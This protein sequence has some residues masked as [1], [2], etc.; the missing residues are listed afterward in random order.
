M[1]I[2]I[3][4]LLGLLKSGLTVQAQ[5][6]VESL[7]HELALRDVLNF[8]LTKFLYSYIIINLLLMPMSIN[9]QNIS[10]IDSLKRELANLDSQKQ[11][12]ANDT[13][14]IQLLYS[15]TKAYYGLSDSSNFYQKRLTTIS[16]GINWPVGKFYSALTAGLNLSGRGKYYEAIEKYY[17][18]LKIAEEINRKNL[19]GLALR[20]LADCFYSLKQYKKSIYYLKKASLLVNSKR[21]YIQYLMCLNNI[22]MSYIELNKLDV[23]EKIL[24]ECLIKNKKSNTNNE[25]IESYCHEQLANLYQK[26][27]LFSKA[28]RNMI[29]SIDIRKKLKTDELYELYPKLAEIYFSKNDLVKAKKFADSSVKYS[30]KIHT[31]YRAQAFEIN[32]KIYKQLGESRKSLYYY[33]RYITLRDSNESN[34]VKKIIDGMYFEFENNKYQINVKNLNAV[35]KNENNIKLLLF[36][37]LCLFFLMTSILYYLYR[38]TKSQKTKIELISE[39]YKMLNE[40]LEERIQVRTTE[41]TIKNEELLRKNQEIQEAYFTGKI[42]ERKR[43]ASELHDNLGS[44]ITGLLWQIDAINTDNFSTRERKIYTSLVMK[45]KEIYSEIRHISH[46]LMPE[47]L[48]IGFNLALNKLIYNMNSNEKIKFLL[49]GSFPNDFVSKTDELEIYSIVLELI[50]NIIKHSKASVCQIILKSTNEEWIIIQKDDGIGFAAIEI[51]KNGLGKGLKN[52]EERVKSI[53]GHLKIQS[54]LGQGAEF[55]VYIPKKI[56]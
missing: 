16:N 43:V 45:M 2:R 20:S 49:T 31:F 28:E 21:T 6:V 50:S 47:E 41:L 1:Q 22:G 26:K 19:N 34:N 27:K 32:Y 55:R 24:I 30:Q 9:G 54:S 12:F 37:S 5:T 25:Y 52:I 7:R 18:S 15:L 48:N 53:G 17:Q 51:R 40:N 56:T 4:L 3:G 42:Y 11:S 36:S 38:K 23:A 39:E 13:L 14:Q 10:R 35:L 8:K 44:T 29:K 33:E 46:N